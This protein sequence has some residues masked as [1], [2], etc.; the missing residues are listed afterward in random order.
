[1]ITNLLLNDPS[2]VQVHTH[3]WGL[4]RAEMKRYKRAGEASQGIPLSG[5]QTDGR[6]AMREIRYR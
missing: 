6:G 3:A 5:L 2:V 4:I 1:M